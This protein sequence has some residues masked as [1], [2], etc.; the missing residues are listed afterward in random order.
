MFIAGVFV[1]F[2]SG[3]CDLLAILYCRLLGL[4]LC[5]IASLCDLFAIFIASLCDLLAI[6]ITSLSDLIPMFYCKSLWPYGYVL[7]QVSV[8]FLIC[9]LEVS[10]TLFLCFIA[11]LCNLFTMWP[12]FLVL[13]LTQAEPLQWDATPWNMILSATAFALGSYLRP[14]N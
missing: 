9:L 12:L 8:T 7:L 10:V 3:L 4:W 2:I 5:F 1:T 11:G 13:Y 14:R 6:F